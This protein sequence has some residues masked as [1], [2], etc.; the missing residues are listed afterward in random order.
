M[1]GSGRGEP[2]HRKRVTKL[3]LTD[4]QDA[5]SKRHELSASA[6]GEGVEL[7]PRIQELDLDQMVPD[8]L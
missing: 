8:G 5:V 6:K 2:G 4:N 7:H 3:E 1:Q